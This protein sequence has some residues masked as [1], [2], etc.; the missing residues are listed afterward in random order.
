MN[1]PQFVLLS[2]TWPGIRIG[3]VSRDFADDISILIL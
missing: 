1:Q 2:C 3:R